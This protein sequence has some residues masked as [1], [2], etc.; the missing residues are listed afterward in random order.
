MYIGRK[1]FSRIALSTNRIQAEW[2][3]A[4]CILECVLTE[5][6]KDRFCENGK[7]RGDIFFLVSPGFRCKVADCFIHM[8]Y[9]SEITLLI[10]LNGMHVLHRRDSFTKIAVCL[11][12]TY[13]TGGITAATVTVQ[14]K[15]K[16]TVVIKR[17]LA[18]SLR[19]N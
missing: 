12:Y 2:I 1:D 10:I 6:R 4:E 15:D 11:L 16:N 14:W 9:S 19:K 7:R 18:I 13:Y 17:L 3:L 8:Y 5:R